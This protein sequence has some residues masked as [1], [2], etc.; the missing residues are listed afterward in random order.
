MNRGHPIQHLSS[1]QK[2]NLGDRADRNHLPKACFRTPEPFRT[3][4]VVPKESK[5]GE[6]ARGFMSA[7]DVDSSGFDIG[8]GA[9]KQ[10]GISHP[11]RVEERVE[12]IRAEP[13]SESL[14]QRGRRVIDSL[15]GY[16]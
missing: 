15:R 4:H 9:G 6:E 5:G 8:F 3:E 16:P 12:L 10:Q 11:E 2:E 1:Q 13:F 7:R 14:V